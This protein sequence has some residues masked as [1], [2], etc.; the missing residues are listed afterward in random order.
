MYMFYKNDRLKM[1]FLCIVNL[2]VVGTKSTGQGKD[3]F[4]LSHPKMSPMCRIKQVLKVK[5]TFK[6]LKVSKRFLSEL[7]L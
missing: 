4:Y 5:Q 7:S 1:L 3:M 6:S 2:P